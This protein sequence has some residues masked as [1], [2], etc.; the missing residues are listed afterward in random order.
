MQVGVQVG[1]PANIPLHVDG[2]YQVDDQLL[3]NT[4]LLDELEEVSLHP[5]HHR[6]DDACV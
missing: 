6:E 5:H 1:K 4:L 2:E 3:H